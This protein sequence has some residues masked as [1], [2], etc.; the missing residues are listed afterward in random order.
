[1]LMMIVEGLFLIVN[2]WVSGEEDVEIVLE[3][4]KFFVVECKVFD[5]Y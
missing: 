5:L 1:M 4:L 3:G 2:R